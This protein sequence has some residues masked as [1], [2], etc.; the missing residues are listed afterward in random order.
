MAESSKENVQVFDLSN[1][2]DIYRWQRLC[3][4]IYGMLTWDLPQQIEALVTA[5]QGMIKRSSRGALSNLLHEDMPVILALYAMEHLNETAPHAPLAAKEMLL[6]CLSLSYSQLFGDKLQDPLK[7]FLARMDW[8]LDG[9]K[10]DPS[11]A[12]SFILSTLLEGKLKDATP[13]V[14][15]LEQTM[16]PKMDRRMAV[17]WRSEFPA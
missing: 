13:L 12:L 16:L 7:H 17:A 5:A 6:P 8:F 1:L 15:Y 10:G 11:E 3:L 4:R 2:P 14:Q 9:E